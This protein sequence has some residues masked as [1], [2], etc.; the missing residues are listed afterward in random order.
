MTLRTSW[1][2]LG[3]PSPKVAAINLLTGER[4]A[5]GEAIDLRLAAHASAAYRLH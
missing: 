5:R 4:I 2:S 3:S 1:H